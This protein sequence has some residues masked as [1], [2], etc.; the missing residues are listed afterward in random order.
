MESQDSKLLKRITFIPGLMGGKPTIRGNRFTVID[1]LEMLSSGM[2]NEEILEEHPILEGE[3]I[4]AAL[5]FSAKQL[6]DEYIYE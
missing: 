3:D 1:I 4:R 6:R 5:V 2:T